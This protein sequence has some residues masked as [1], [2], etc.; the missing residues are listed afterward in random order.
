MCFA[1]T[2][3]AWMP[4]IFAMASEVSNTLW[5]WVCSVITSPSSWAMA[6]EGPMEPCIW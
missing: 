1:T 6:H 3:W 2:F 5:L 4:N